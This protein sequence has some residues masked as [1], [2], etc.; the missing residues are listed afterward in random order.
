M[1][2]VCRVRVDVVKVCR[3]RV[4]VVKVCMVRVDVVK[5]CRVRVDVVKGLQ[6]RSHT[7]FTAVPVLSLSVDTVL[8]QLP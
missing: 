6:S 3:V 5:V 7:S 1:R 4:D 2:E 8:E